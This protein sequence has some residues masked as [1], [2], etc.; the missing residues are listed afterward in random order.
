MKRDFAVE[1]EKR[2]AFIKECL[3]NAGADALVFGN[4]GGKDSALAGILCK[5]ACQK[6]FCIAMPCGVKQNFT[7][8]MSDA[9]LLAKKYDI[10]M[11]VL[12]LTR[13]KDDLIDSFSGNLLLSDNAKINIAPRLRMTALYAAAASKN[14]LVAGT[15]NASEYAVGYFTKWGDGAYDINP[16]ADLTATEVFEFLRFLNAPASIIDKAPS[17]ALKEDQT[18]EKEMG[19][20]YAQLDSYLTTGSA[21]KDVKEK[22]DALISRSEHKRRP[23]LRFG[24]N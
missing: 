12:D 16:V 3:K 7:S 20:T 4:S 24:R 23:P 18:D 15:G 22:A 2:V 6:T 9:E 11:L 1:T 8:D 10:E 13:V 14:A 19:L 21:P 17:A 5:K